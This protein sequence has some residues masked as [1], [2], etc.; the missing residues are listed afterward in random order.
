MKPGI[1]LT[2]ALYLKSNVELHIGKEVTLKAVNRVE[3]FPDRATR[4]AG[5][6]MVWPAAIINVINQENVAITGEGV[7][8][9]DGKYLW[10]KYWAMRKDYDEQGL[11]WIVDYDCKQVRSLLV[12]ESTNVTVSDLTFL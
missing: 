9:G 3:D 8:D 5:I 11:R 1:Y 4:V 7:I 6:E 2:G 10:D 12:S